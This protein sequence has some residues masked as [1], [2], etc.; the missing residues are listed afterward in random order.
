MEFKCPSAC[1]KAFQK[2]ENQLVQ[3]Y[4]KVSIPSS[5]F[6]DQITV[7]YLSDLFLAK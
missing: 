2:A 3:L 6:V 5:G 4:L 1:P 7:T